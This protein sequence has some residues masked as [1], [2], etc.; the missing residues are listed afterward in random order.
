MFFDREKRPALNKLLALILSLV[1]LTGCDSIDQNINNLNFISE[2]H[3]QVAE[4][5][6]PIRENVDLDYPTASLSELL[7]AAKETT[8][9]IERSV[10]YGPCSQEFC[11][12]SDIGGIPDPIWNFEKNYNGRFGLKSK[13]ASQDFMNPN[14][15][16]S[17]FMTKAPADAVVRSWSGTDTVGGI[18]ELDFG[19]GLVGRLMHLDYENCVNNFVPG[20]QVLSGQSLCIANGSGTISGGSHL[21]FELKKDGV[22]VDP[23]NYFGSPIPENNEIATANNINDENESGGGM[24]AENGEANVNLNVIFDETFVSMAYDG[25]G[26][27]YAYNEVLPLINYEKRTGHNYIIIRPGDTLSFNGEFAKDINGEPDQFIRGYLDY[28]QP[29]TGNVIAGG[30]V[31]DTAQKL[32]TAAVASGLSA[33]QTNI[34]GYEVAPHPIG[35][36]VDPACAVTIWIDYAEQGGTNRRD[37]EIYNPFSYP[38]KF[39]W[40]VIDV[41]TGT[42]RIWV[43]RV[44]DDASLLPENNQERLNNNPP[45]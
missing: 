34:D 25:A 43:E 19:Q 14:G 17:D 32:C 1:V 38:I 13:H 6:D 40:Q 5:Q 31:C 22:K 21:H 42:Y 7:V 11:F 30:G 23:M 4:S 3:A 10:N 24:S 9:N 15:S 12:T 37:L 39:S 8:N 20:Q 27:A 18:L 2:V 35:P 29:S 41:S 45:V 16:Y 33:W 44:L 28:V 36:K 26:G